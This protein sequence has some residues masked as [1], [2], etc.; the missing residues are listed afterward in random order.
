MPTW[1]PTAADHRFHVCGCMRRLP[2]DDMDERLARR[3]LAA[4]R[5]RV[6]AKLRELQERLAMEEREAA[7]EVADYDQHQA[8]AGRSSTSASATM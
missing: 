7:G 8:D 1:T 3:L 5:N 2:G 4:E 6:P